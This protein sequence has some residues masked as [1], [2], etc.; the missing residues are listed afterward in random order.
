MRTEL[1]T[2]RLE[3]AAGEARGVIVFL[4]GILGSGANFRS[5]ARGVLDASPG[6]GALLVDLR[7]HGASLGMEPP[8]TLQRAAEDVARVLPSGALRLVMVGHSFGGKVALEVTRLLGGDLDGC[9]VLDA[10]PG[11]RDGGRGSE[12]VL[13][14]VEV[15][16]RLPRVFGER[17]AFVDALTAAGISRPTIDWL[18]MNLRRDG[19]TFVFRLD[20]DAITG[21]LEDY[22]ARDLWSVV[23]APPGRV[24]LDVVVGGRSAVFDEGDRARLQR[25]ASPRVRAHVL[26]EAG[27]W[28]H[29]DDPDGLFRVV[30]GALPPLS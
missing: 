6:W 16:K 21:M 23:E 3:P 14:V 5:F 30:H 7:M 12:S 17:R 27:H 11:A 18:A 1:H 25:A 15:L 2:T 22:F 19:D 13:H 28:V 9:V 10:T 26:A 24:T 20:L 4:H 29:V 8:H